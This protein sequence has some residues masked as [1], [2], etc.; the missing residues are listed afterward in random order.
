M[1]PTP[2]T[3]VRFARISVQVTTA[4]TSTSTPRHAVAALYI[5]P[6]QHCHQTHGPV[7][8]PTHSM[9]TQAMNAK[10]KH[11]AAA[12]VFPSEVHPANTTFR[13]RTGRTK[14]RTFTAHPTD[15]ARRP[16]RSDYT[17]TEAQ[18]VRIANET[19]SLVTRLQK[20][21]SRPV[22]V[23]AEHR[24]PPRQLP[25]REAHHARNRCAP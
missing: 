5:I 1:Q 16:P 4:T 17:H 9:N 2:F 8:L 19:K 14:S 22:A 23:P 24:S 6:S 12:M 10:L 7:T 21:Y 13:T 25:C 15:C 3:R 18:L 20:V 11:I